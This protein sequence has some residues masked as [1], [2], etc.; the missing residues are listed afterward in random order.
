M[1]LFK[2]T[3]H[4]KSLATWP[5]GVISIMLAL[6]AG[7]RVNERYPA[8]SFMFGLAGVAMVIR[9]VHMAATSEHSKANKWTFGIICCLAIVGIDSV[10]I[11]DTLL[12]PQRSV[13]TGARAET[14]GPAP[15]GK[16]EQQ[17]EREQPQAVDSAA[18][19]AD[20]TTPATGAG[21]RA[22]TR[23][24]GAGV[25]QPPPVQHSPVAVPAPAI[26]VSPSG[27]QA[28][29]ELV[30]PDRVPNVV[31]QPGDIVFAAEGGLLRLDREMKPQ[32]ILVSDD[33]AD[34]RG[35]AV[36]A[37]GTVLVST[38]A[39]G[40]GTILRVDPRT[41]RRTI[42][43]T[44]FRTPKAILIEPGGT[45]LVADEVGGSPTWG[46]LWRINLQTGEQAEVFRFAPSEVATGMGVD[47]K[48]GDI[49]FT[50]RGLYR[51]RP[52]GVSRMDVEGI[53]N[54]TSMTMAGGN[55]VV[56]GEGPTVVEMRPTGEMIGPL[57]GG[58]P[59]SD[60]AARGKQ[61]FVGY[62]NGRVGRIRE[63]DRAAENVWEG[64]ASNVGVFLAVVPDR[65]PSR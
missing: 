6:A 26:V 36:E 64:R 52:E 16:P 10:F 4:W 35:V 32:R 19:R 1:G 18:P 63:T 65:A 54:P 62:G 14:A 8:A 38:R 5:I 3:F 55:L 34:V 47:A 39:C 50:R 21:G 24:D 58:G 13:A 53:L 44:G 12:Q 42:L 40:G 22:R 45:L 27:Q 57:A 60:L 11:W 20:R 15:D 28:A 46:Y 61:V 17:T 33:L 29:C 56:S 48:S 43:A 25:A 9:V 41:G 49:F 59:I 37:S 31:L 7:L 51:L 2:E 23:A 30:P